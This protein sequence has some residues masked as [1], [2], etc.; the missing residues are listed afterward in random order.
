MLFIVKSE[1]LLIQK[2][3]VGVADGVDA[4]DF[5]VEEGA[6][7]VDVLTVGGGDEDRWGA[8]AFGEPGVLKHLEGP[9]VAGHGC[10]VVLLL[11][12][13]GIGI[14][15]VE[16]H[17]R[18]LIERL[19]FVEGTVDRLDLLLEAAVGDVD[20]MDE[21]VRFAY[22]VEGRFER[23]DQTVRQF[24]DKSD[25]VGEEERQVVDHHLADRGVEGGEEFV[26]RKDVRLGEEIH[27]GGLADI[28]IAYQSH[29]DQTLAIFALLHFLLV[30][31]GEPFFEQCDFL[32]NE[33]AVGLNLAFAGSA[34]TDTAPLAFE[35]G[36]E[37]G[38]PR[39]HILQLSQFDLRFGDGGACPAGE[40]VEN[41]RGA[42]EDTA[43]ESPLEVAEL[44]RREFVVENDKIG[45]E[46]VLVFN[47]LLQF[48]AADI[49]AAVGSVEFL[50]DCLEGDATCRFEEESQ[51]VET[52]L[53]VFHG[54]AGITYRDEDGPFGFHV[55]RESVALL[56]GGTLV[57]T[58][59]NTR[60]AFPLAFV[61]LPGVFFH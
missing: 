21:E 41:Q 51:F 60:L 57:L 36:P 33:T 43:V 3:I 46:G 19:Q 58:F 47:D 18:R 9:V 25:G 28:G 22:L 37:T 12:G 10:K 32:G 38:E 26:L 23:F 7:R 39:E 40:D 34:H 54:G 49:G 16:D 29:T 11:G 55:R 42:V 4:L 15:L 14:N 27:Q 50:D 35:V 17:N 56:G 1:N 45:V 24:A 6:E 44:S 20:N 30:D 8:V 5:V 61:G 13:E 48:A 31:G 52:L 2:I 59:P 53:G